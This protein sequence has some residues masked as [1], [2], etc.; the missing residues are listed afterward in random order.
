LEWYGRDGFTSPRVPRTF[1]FNSPPL[2]LYYSH[3]PCCS[4]FP[5][6][7]GLISGGQ[8]RRRI[9]IVKADLF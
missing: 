8:G 6:I 2:S 3:S 5:D 9:L 4:P 7:A 1:I